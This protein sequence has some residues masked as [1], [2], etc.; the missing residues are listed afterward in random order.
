[1]KNRFVKYGLTLVVVLFI[2]FFGS[3]LISPSESYTDIDEEIKSQLIVNG[4]KIDGIT[5]YGDQVL[6]LLDEKG[7]KKL[8]IGDHAQSVIENVKPWAD[9]Q[10]P[11]S[12]DKDYQGVEVNPDA[13]LLY[14]YGK[15]KDGSN[16][17]EV[18]NIGTK[19]IV[20]EIPFE[21]SAKISNIKFKNGY[22]EGMLYAKTDLE[23]QKAE[24]IFNTT[25]FN[26]HLDLLVVNLPSKT[27]KLDWVDANPDLEYVV[28]TIKDQGKVSAFVH[29]LT[30]NQTAQL[31]KI[32]GDKF[33]F[34]GE[35]LIGFKSKKNKL[36]I[37]EYDYNRTAIKDKQQSQNFDIVIKNGIVLDPD[38]ETIKIGYHVGIKDDKVKAV[39][40]TN[41]QGKTEIDAY[42]KI[43]S[44]GF[45]DM[46][47][48][49][50]NPMAAKFK[51]GDGVTTNLSMHGCTVDFNGFFNQYENYPTSVNYGGA[52]FAV[53]LRYEAGLGN[54]GTPTKEQID[55]MV[56]RAREEIEK[57][58][59]AVAFS[60]EYYPGTTPEE[61]KAIMKVAKEYGIVTHFHGRHSSLTGE[62]T[63]IDS[64]KEVLGYAR[65]LDA[66][67]HFMHLHSTGGTGAMD[68]ALALIQEAR[69]DGYQVTYDVYPYDSWA[70][71]ISFER[72]AGDWQ[73]R[74]GIT[75][76]DIQVAG[77][78]ERLTAETFPQYRKKGGQVIVYAMNED[79][80]IQALQ[81]DH[82]MIGSDATMDSEYNHP[83]GAG[84]FS[85]FIGRYIR[86]L[87]I[88]PLMEGLKKITIHSARQLENTAPAMATRGRLHEGSTADITIF[89]YDEIIDTSTAEKPASL[90]KGIEYVIVSGK[91]A[92]DETGV[93]SYVKNGQPIK[94]TFE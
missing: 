17:M 23:K 15:K 78:T 39:T 80:L 81:V 49:N 79:E 41:I 85:R 69:A 71:D 83:R 34:D 11:K 87:D 90:S 12:P 66:P 10:V 72:L 13:H 91:I 24:I 82:S 65:E 46:L 31:E 35:Q 26:S 75:Y 77:T 33:L 18:I 56:K 27:A 86:D 76:S 22:T 94:G 55:Y 73:S 50:P 38:E 58:A 32:S 92:K 84:T 20:S 63:S 19:E 37:K 45:I 43:V 59:L 6:A 54:H 47:S 25:E 67:V 88:L 2:V 93:L 62:H 28:Y 48:F 30:T 4:F 74:F 57:G 51:I 44:P 8:Y 7:E 61:I 16:F 14:L 40:K 42:Q 3:K 21:D 29:N 9:F 68:E 53:R 70:T 60:P 52:L 1:M 36:S 64:V 89:D 5:F